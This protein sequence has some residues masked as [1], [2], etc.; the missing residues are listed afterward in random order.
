MAV[1]G[2]VIHDEAVRYL[3][4][5]LDEDESLGILVAGKMGVG[6]S[7][8]INSIYGGEIAK[9]GSGA[10][11]VTD[12]IVNFTANIPTPNETNKTKE[13]TLR[14]WD[15]PGFGDIFA[16]NMDKII[17]ELVYVV[18]KAHVLLFCFDIRGRLSKDDAEGLIEITGRIHPDIWR[19][20]VFALTFGNECKPPP[21]NEEN[22][23][24]FLL[25]A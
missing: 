16:K 8:L 10:A 22:P 7:A 15:S 11:S 12:E 13:C 9:E 5:Y 4:E 21:G 14:V 19:N 1:G 17:E 25:M 2:S 20:A 18:D 24:I 6:K 3:E 23:A